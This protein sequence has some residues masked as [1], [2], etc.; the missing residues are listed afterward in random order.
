MPEQ[1]FTNVRHNNDSQQYEHCSGT[2]YGEREWH[3]I[4][5]IQK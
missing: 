3:D 4:K 5:V 1:F 2:E